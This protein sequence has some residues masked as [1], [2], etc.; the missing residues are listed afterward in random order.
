MIRKYFSFYD[1]FII[2]FIKVFVILFIISALYSF[3]FKKVVLADLKSEST[4]EIYYEVKED[5]LVWINYRIKLTNM[6]ENFFIRDYSLLT[7]YTDMLDLQ[8]TEN[9]NQ[10][11]FKK[12]Y[13][14]NRI[15]IRVELNK[16][17]VSKGEETTILI[18]YNTRQVFKNEG[19]AKTIYISPIKTE[20][21][22]KKVSYK[23]FLPKVFSNIS[24]ISDKQAEVINEGSNI[25]V[26]LDNANIKG[27][28]FVILG[29]EQQFEFIYNYRIENND[30]KAKSVSIT[31]PPD[32]MFQ[33][34]FINNISVL[35]DRTYI[36]EDGNNKIEFDIN[37]GEKEDIRISGFTRYNVEK[38]EVAVSE[39]FL[40]NY[41]SDYVSNIDSN[42]INEVLKANT[43]PDYTE[44]EN[45]EFIYNYLISNFSYIETEDV[46]SETDLYTNIL[47]KNLTCENITD[48][49]IILSRRSNIPSRK[50]VGYYLFENKISDLHFWIE[51]YDKRKKTWM[52][53]D[54]CIE[55]NLGFQGFNNIDINRF[56]FAYRGTIQDKP[57]IILPFRKYQDIES[58]NIEVKISAF[59]LNKD[60]KNIEYYYN[61]RRNDLFVDN[62]PL[63]LYIKNNSQ[64]IFRIDKVLIDKEEAVIYENNSTKNIQQAVLPGETRKVS[65]NL[66]DVRN[67]SLNRNENY[68]LE[69]YADYGNNSFYKKEILNLVR[70]FSIYSFLSWCMALILA[71]ITLFF[72]IIISNYIRMSSLNN[73][74]ILKRNT[75]KSKLKESH[76]I[77]VI[78]K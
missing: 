26:Y 54:P 60:E 58:D 71:C 5:G 13:E 43:R 28:L 32:S 73:K 47:K 64:S 75:T 56:I 23:I 72:F 46:N 20:E 18:K 78:L 27:G 53:A 16:K 35:P 66:G 2:F 76:D 57:F 1:N 63:D 70:P 12:E 41:L 50:V 45:A 10:V 24:Y 68:E 77:P 67:L 48:L 29:N 62:I 74:F 3:F 59:D 25:I 40:K 69:I 14:N 4:Y 7:N 15:R 6:S 36:D 9:D 30:T 19:L 44:Y 39:N 52:N 31:L 42:Y 65:L 11:N 22:L 37:P 55:L 51:F 21:E 17:L 49:Y 8:V 38:K 61:I 34:V 33:E